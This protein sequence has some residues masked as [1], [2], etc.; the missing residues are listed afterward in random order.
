MNEEID[1][2]GITLVADE[3]IKKIERIE[4]LYKDVIDN[5]A[6]LK[7][8]RPDVASMVFDIRDS[9]DKEFQKYKNQKSNWAKIEK[10]LMEYMEC[11]AVAYRTV[12]K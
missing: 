6:K 12:S 2:S 8:E 5:W 3:I 11:M 1:A 7:I 4:V 9:I 10:I